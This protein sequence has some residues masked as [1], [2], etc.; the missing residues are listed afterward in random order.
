MQTTDKLSRPVCA[1]VIVVSA[2]VLSMPLWMPINGH[3]GWIHLNWLEQFT[4]LFREGD[5]YPRW[6]PDSFSGF[7]SPAFYFYPPLT[8]WLASVISFTGLHD[9]ESLF[10][11]VTTITLFLS[12]LT[13][14]WYAREMN[15]SKNIAL[16]GAICY[17]VAPYRMID[18][19]IRN[20]LSE[21]VAFVWIPIVFIGIERWIL[22]SEFGKRRVLG[23][24]CFL[25]GF[26][27]LTLTN[28]PT[29][30]II[31][32][33]SFVYIAFRSS[34]KE[35]LLRYLLFAF[36][37]SIVLICCIF[38]IAPIEQY[39]YEMR[40]Y[41]LLPTLDT[42]F[43]YSWVDNFGEM[44]QQ[45]RN[46]FLVISSLISIV[47]IGMLLQSK[48]VIGKYR[49]I[50]TLLCVGIIVQ[51]PFVSYFVHRKSL[52]QFIQHDHRWQIMLVFAST[53]GLMVLSKEWKRVSSIIKGLVI[54][55]G[56]AVPCIVTL[57]FITHD[58][59]DIV[60]NYHNDP[61]EYINRSVASVAIK[62][63]EYFATLGMNQF[64]EPVA[65]T[66]DSAVSLKWRQIRENVYEIEKRS[67]G[68]VTVRFAMQQFPSWWLSAERQQT[69][70][71]DSDSTGL[72]TAKLPSGQGVYYLHLVAK[73]EDSYT[74][75]SL[76]SIG[77]I[78]LTL[79]GLY[80]KSRIKASS[81]SQ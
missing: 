2:F 1:L 71:T 14:Y 28:L 16:L 50:I 77:L 55:S 32:I 13:F 5:L 74:L 63:I 35:L 42:I 59:R 70:I 38:Y 47:T 29:L 20:A 49:F 10:H 33:S 73:G 80:G 64:I 17:S 24:G 34:L 62:P 21:H 41:R 22:S 15:F 26:I 27:G 44:Y 19:A 69:I 51:I 78:S 53:F 65:G 75:I 39:Q 52:G 67:D 7:G 23:A 48:E 25:A 54:S 31:G 3:D 56:V 76:L 66:Y 12:G 43:I 18:I 36:G 8:Y 81:Q 37:A 79:F 4:Q 57:F 61:P 60:N 46:V 9:G 68:D 11:A 40:T 72:L 30:F 6:M 58:S 45:Y